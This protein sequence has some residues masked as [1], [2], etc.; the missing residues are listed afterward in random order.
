MVRA[1]SQ[2]ALHTRF[3]HQLSAVLF[4]TTVL[5]Y[6]IV[7]MKLLRPPRTTD[8]SQRI[9][10]NFSIWNLPDCV[11]DIDGKHV[12]IKSHLNNGPLQFNYKV[13]FR[14]VLNLNVPI[15]GKKKK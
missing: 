12:T 10:Q 15:P 8:N 11:G 9:T 14:T 13:Y 7:A 2:F 6:G 3:E 1:T 4:N 5:L